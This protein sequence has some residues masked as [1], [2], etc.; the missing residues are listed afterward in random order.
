MEGFGEE[1]PELSGS[2]I[3]MEFGRGGRI[4]QLWASDPALPDEGEDFQFVLPPLD[5]D[6]SVFSNFDET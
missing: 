6:D 2:L 3:S 1:R 5:F 4:M